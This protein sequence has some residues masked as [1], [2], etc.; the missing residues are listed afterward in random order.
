MTDYTEGINEALEAEGG[1][2][3]A[4]ET[5]KVYITLPHVGTC[6][7]TVPDDAEDEDYA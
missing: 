6:T 4:T 3:N 5:D 1:G 7:L 2:D